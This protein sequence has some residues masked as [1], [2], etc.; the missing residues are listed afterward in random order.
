MEKIET[1]DIT[2]SAS[3]ISYMFYLKYGYQFEPTNIGMVAKQFN[4]NYINVKNINNLS[5][6]KPS[7]EYYLKDLRIFF[8]HLQIKMNRKLSFQNCEIQKK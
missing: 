6:W 2:C 4:L 1:N 3:E 8:I 7:K 5:N